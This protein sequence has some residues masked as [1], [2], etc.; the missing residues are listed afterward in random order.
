MSRLQDKT[1]TIEDLAAMPM[2]VKLRMMHEGLVDNYLML[3][4]T[5]KL[6]PRDMAPMMTLLKQNDIKEEKKEED[7]MHDKVLKAME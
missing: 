5:G 3:L 2:E 1:Y 6:H 7:S 4:Q